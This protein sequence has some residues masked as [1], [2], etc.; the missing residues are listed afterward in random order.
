MKS[1]NSARFIAIALL[2][3][4][5]IPVR[6]TAQEQ[7]SKKEHHRYRLIELGTFGGPMSY[8]NPVGNGGPYMNRRGA[9]V[10]SS[11]TFISLP[12]NNNGFPCVAPASDVFHAFAWQEGAVTDLG[13]LGTPSNCA[14]ALGINDAGESVGNSE[15]GKV[16]PLTGFWETRAVLWKEGHIKNLGTFGGSQSLASSINNRGQIVGFA[17]NNIPD[18]FSIFDNLFGGSTNGTQTRA[19]LWQNGHKHDLDTLG[20]PDAWATFV[21][22]RGQV[23]GYS[24][25]NSTPNPTGVP[26]ADP[27]LW[28]K[29][30][31]I[32]DLGTLGGTFGFPVGLNNRGQVIGQSNLAGDQNVDAFLWDGKK[33][34]DLSTIGVGGSFIGG[35]TNAINDAG[36][37]AGA[38][39]FP[40][41]PFDAAIW[42]NGVVTDLG[43]LPG[44]CASEALV[45]NFKGQVAGGSFSCDGIAEHAFL[46][47]DG[48]MYDLTA[49]ISRHSGSRMVEPNAI[50][51]RGE[52]A[53]DGLPAGCSPSNFSTCSQAY[54]LVPC[55][56]VQSDEEGCED[57]EGSTAE[58][59]RSSPPV[60]RPADATQSRLTPE[61]LAELRARWTRRYHVPGLAAPKY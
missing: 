25:I 8:I 57:E 5:A 37:I 49:L 28:T 44:D 47:E 42:R 61:M 19:F 9:V 6:A 54:V 34:I 41:H 52:I 20:G 46:W 17:L 4:L 59:Q 40:N 23:A 55:N 56:H 27:F 39:A 58:T 18:P 10:G 36:W 32:I 43:V 3:A 14:N 29:K 7:Q 16:D 38:A 31:G 2:A 15:N 11:M 24:Y 50:N 45:L 35:H 48:K 51:D 53:T 60:T 21:N 33:L 22:E 13:S 12:P 26:T 30:G 1:K